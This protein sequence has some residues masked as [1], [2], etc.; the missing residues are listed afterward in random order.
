[1]AFELKLRSCQGD[2]NSFLHKFYV[3][4]LGFLDEES[5]RCRVSCLFV[6]YYKSIVASLGL[7]DALR[8]LNSLKNLECAF[9]SSVPYV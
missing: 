6:H 4:H 7:W 1:M 9:Q 3:V 8:I 2:R 5:Y